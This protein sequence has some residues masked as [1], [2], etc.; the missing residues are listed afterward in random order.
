[1][2][3]TDNFLANDLL[4][5]DSDKESKVILMNASHYKGLKSETID[6][7]KLQ[8]SYPMGAFHYTKDPGIFARKSNGK[9]CF[10]SFRMEYSGSPLEAVQNISVGIL[11]SILSNGVIPLLL[12]TYVG[13]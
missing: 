1:M 8:V 3:Q 12:F 11:R 7:N 2:S 9:V 13:N 5:V 10:G 4:N 6:K